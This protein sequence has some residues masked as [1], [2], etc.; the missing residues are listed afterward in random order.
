MQKLVCFFLFMEILSV[1]SAFPNFIYY[2]EPCSKINLQS[3]QIRSVLS[4]LSVTKFISLLR[5][6]TIKKKGKDCYQIF[7]KKRGKNKKKSLFFNNVL[8]F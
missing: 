6:Q 5:I 2:S 1:F 3:E 4:D 7:K 8:L